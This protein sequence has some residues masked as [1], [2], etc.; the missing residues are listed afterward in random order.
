MK[1]VID[2]SF[3]VVER[4]WRQMLHTLR[5]VSAQSVRHF[6]PKPR[7]SWVITPTSSN[8]GERAAC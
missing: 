7:G 4:D 1:S 2:T 5:A 8:I 6:A 3:L